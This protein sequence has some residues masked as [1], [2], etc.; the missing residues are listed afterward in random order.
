M[1]NFDARL[2]FIVFIILLLVS[3]SR[4]EAELTVEEEKLVSELNYD[5]DLMTR[6]KSVGKS[7]DR[8]IGVDDHDG[9]LPTNALILSIAPNQGRKALSDIWGIF[10]GTSYK[11]YLYDDVFGY[12]DDQI[13]ILKSKDQ[14]DCLATVR[15]DGINYDLT[16]EKVLAQYK[17]WNDKYGLILIGG[18]HDWIEAKFSTPPSDWISF[19]NEVYSF[20]P[21]IVDQGVGDV[22]SLAAEMK[23]TNTLYLWWD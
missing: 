7:Y 5:I 6:V 19:A 21:D 8:F 16:H 18:A 20:C 23:A 9:S 15:T 11:V 2:I 4:G 17:V 3:C 14:F 13:I 1:K 22:E 12:A 10:S